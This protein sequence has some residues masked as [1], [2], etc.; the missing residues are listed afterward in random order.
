M[1]SARHKK[2]FLRALAT[3]PVFLKAARELLA[4]P[5]PPV[6]TKKPAA[7]LP[8]VVATIVGEYDQ[9]AHNDRMEARERAEDAARRQPSNVRRA[10]ARD[11]WPTSL[12]E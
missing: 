3:D 1:F 7:D 10:S 6:K 8:Y 12:I 5:P 11:P 2:S 9:L 4:P